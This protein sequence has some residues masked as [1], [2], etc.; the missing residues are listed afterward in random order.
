VQHQPQQLPYLPGISVESCVEQLL[1]LGSRGCA[2]EHATCVHAVWPTTAIAWGAQHNTA[3][4]VLL[5]QLFNS[6]ALLIITQQ[7]RLSANCALIMHT[8]V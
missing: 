4:Q 8:A 1:G 2:V 5:Q 7:F 3:N 6:S